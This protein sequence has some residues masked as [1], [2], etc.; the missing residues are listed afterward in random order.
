V[1]T[2][3]ILERHTR[4]MIGRENVEHNKRSG[5]TTCQR[6]DE[7]VQ[8]ERNLVRLDIHLSINQAYCMEILK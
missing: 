4:F 2:S 6:T 1:K 3:S 5:C 8:E 7:N